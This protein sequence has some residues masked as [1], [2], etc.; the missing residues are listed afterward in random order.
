VFLCS[1]AETRRNPRFLGSSVSN[2][3]VR[4]NGDLRAC[5]YL[6]SPAGILSIAEASHCPDDGELQPVRKVQKILQPRLQIL[7]GLNGAAC[8]QVSADAAA[9]AEGRRP[10][11][12]RLRAQGVASLGCLTA[13]LNEEGILTPRRPL[14]RFVRA[15]PD[16][17]A[18]PPG[19]SGERSVTKSL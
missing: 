7:D 1:R 19:C 16:G 14:A 6:S 9:F 3:T 4:G 18:G 11:V 17:P 5:R 15:E 2:L 12:T 8:T 10:T 13:A